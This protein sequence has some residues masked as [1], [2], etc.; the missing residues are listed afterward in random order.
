MILEDGEM[1]FGWQ[2]IETDADV[3]RLL[4]AFGGF[5]DACLRE[6]HIWS[7]TYVNEDLSMACPSHLDTHVRLLFQ[8]Q[9]RN[10]T[11]IELLFDEVISFHLAPA[12]EN[13]S[14]E[15]GDAALF[16]L[17]NVIY[18]ADDWQWRPGCDWQDESTWIAAQRLRW[19]DASTWMG[20]QLRYGPRLER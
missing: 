4:S 1:P 12:P 16:I 19:R 2:S 7:E 13:Y 15:I 11:A 9:W 18:W 6:A 5:H 3:E 8:R 20:E 17:D 14:N 10:P